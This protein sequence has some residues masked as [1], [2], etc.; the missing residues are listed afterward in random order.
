MG[1]LK[2]NVICPAH[3]QYW[4]QTSYQSWCNPQ[5]LACLFAA[6]RALDNMNYQALNGRPMRIMWSHRYISNTFSHI[7]QAQTPDTPYMPAPYIA[8]IQRLHPSLHHLDI[9][10]CISAC[11]G[12]LQQLVAMICCNNLLAVRVTEHM[13]TVQRPISSQIRS[14]QYLHQEPRQGD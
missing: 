11:N 7:F 13:G 12:P 10:Y 9:A 2:Q 5:R 4:T 6:E 3:L 8:C 1:L 14:G